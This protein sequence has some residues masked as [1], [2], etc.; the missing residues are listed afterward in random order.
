MKKYLFIGIA[1]SI[2]SSY[3]SIV[4]PLKPDQQAR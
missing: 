2:L 4:P 1:C 3:K